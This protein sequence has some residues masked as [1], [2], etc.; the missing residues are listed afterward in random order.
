MEPPCITIDDTQDII[1]PESV[2]A[3]LALPV[4]PRKDQRSH[5]EMIAS[6][7]QDRV[8]KNI[9]VQKVAEKYNVAPRTIQT[10]VKKSGKIVPR[11]HAAK[12]PRRKPNK[13]THFSPSESPS[14][15]LNLP[16]PE[17][18]DNAMDMIDYLSLFY[19]FWCRHNFILGHDELWFEQR[20]TLKR[21]C[22]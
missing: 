2:P 8:E 17:A 6:A 22:G 15:V 21:W 9:S 5:A 7:V 19:T 11:K 3:T 12:Q 13:S 16:P 10:W 1:S 14:R 20:L 18:C 4:T